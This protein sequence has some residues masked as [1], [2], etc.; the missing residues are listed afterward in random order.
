MADALDYG[1]FGRFTN[2]DDHCFPVFA[3]FS[4]DPNFDQLMMI[5]RQQDFVHDGWGKPASADNDH[6]FAMMGQ[7]FEMTFL[8]VVERG[9]GK[10]R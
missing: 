10:V 5:Q 4:I 6:R 8:R 2:L 3:L 1:C 9:H 7:G